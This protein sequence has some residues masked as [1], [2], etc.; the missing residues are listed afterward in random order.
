MADTE[1]N[2]TRSSICLVRWWFGDYL[3]YMDCVLRSCAANPDIDWLLLTDNP[4][5]KN[6]RPMSAPT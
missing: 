3:P 1:K 4:S 6:F 2:P 5:R